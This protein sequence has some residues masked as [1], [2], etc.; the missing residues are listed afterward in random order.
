MIWEVCSRTSLQLA[1]LTESNLVCIKGPLLIGVFLRT[2]WYAVI[3]RK[4]KNN[5]TDAFNAT[6]LRITDHRCRSI[7]PFVR[8]FRYGGCN[9]KGMVLI[10]GLQNWVGLARHLGFGWGGSHRTLAYPMVIMPNL[11]PSASSMSAY[12][13]LT[14]KII[15]RWDKA[16]VR[17]GGQFDHW[18]VRLSRCVTVPTSV[19]LGQRRSYSL[20]KNT[21]QPSPKFEGF[22]GDR[23]PIP[24]SRL[25]VVECRLLVR[26]WVFRKTEKAAGSS[27]GTKFSRMME[28]I[29]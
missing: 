17:V 3:W 23:P 14:P 19:A 24:C 25:V 21:D 12:K 6:Y 16:L 20:T 9:S 27:Q 4:I 26:L 1:K 2:I 29:K 18:N 7:S 13:G 28:K 10:E 15:A 8:P 5:S 22:N 11:V